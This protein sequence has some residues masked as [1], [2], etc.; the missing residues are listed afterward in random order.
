MNDA[1][2]PHLR[3]T[4]RR[5]DDRLFYCSSGRERQPRTDLRAGYRVDANGK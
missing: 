1:V 5:A 3:E 2:G 4:Y